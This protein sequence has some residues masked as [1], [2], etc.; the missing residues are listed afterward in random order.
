MIPHF[1]TYESLI[2]YIHKLDPVEYGKTR[3][4]T[5]GAVTYL[6]PFI[7]RGIIST[8]I[9]YE[10]MI[11][12][13]FE[14]KQIESFVKELCWRDYFQRVWQERNLDTEIKQAQTKQTF[15]DLPSVIQEKS[16]SIPFFNEQFEQLEATGYLH[17]HV[18]MYL[19]SLICNIGQY[20]WKT[21]AQWMYYHLLDGDWASNACSWQ[22]VCGAN[23][24]K[25]YVSSEENITFFTKSTVS[26][27]YLNRFHQNPFETWIPDEWNDSKTLLLKTNLPKVADLK[28]DNS[29]PTCIYN[30]YNIDPQWK[31]ELKANRVLLLEPHIFEKY[32]VSDLCIQFL[33]TYA[34]WIDEIQIFVGSFEEFQSIHNS[35][36]PIYFKEHPLNKHYQGIEEQRD[37]IVNSVQGYF[38]SFFA[39]WKA[40]TPFLKS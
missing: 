31:K 3:N 27:S 22:W 33:L 10:I 35:K 15:Q 28:L 6:S 32:P 8:K 29:L 7:S 36:E 17:N 20:H 21:P 11:K 12:R 24:Q 39:Y 18:R 2:E 1:E 26:N 25:M 40:C 16:L 4:F 14:L 38:P 37:W 13:G 30:Y 9:V 34:Q 5:N 19:A 23:S